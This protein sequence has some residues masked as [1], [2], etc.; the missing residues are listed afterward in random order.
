MKLSIVFIALVS[1]L[2]SCVASKTDMGQHDAAQ[3]AQAFEMLESFAGR[4][5]GT[6]VGAESQGPVE[7]S[8]EVTSGGSVVMERLFRGS[9]HEMV[10]MYHRDG[11]R[12][13]MT[14]YCSQGNQPRMQ[15]DSFTASPETRAS[16]SLADATNWKG[17]QALIMHNVRLYSTDKD[18]MGADWVAWVNGK[19]DHSASFAFKRVP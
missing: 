19:P 17:P 15:L 2:T 11:E 9:P 1:I 8:Y 7:L 5:Q 6:M 3:S 10:S 14:H 12:L 16:F 18:H 13:L 4:W